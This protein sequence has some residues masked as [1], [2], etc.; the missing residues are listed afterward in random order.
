MPAKKIKV[1]IDTNL[2]I[3][4]L[5]GKKLSKLKKLISHSGI[6]LIFSHQHILELKLVTSRSKFN[7]YFNQDNVNELIDLIYSFGRIV[8]VTEE[9]EVCRDPKDNFL[10]GLAEKSKAN[11]LVSGDNDLLDMNHYKK[12]KIVSAE[13]FSK[14]IETNF[15]NS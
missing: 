15:L 2:F 7:K 3:S 4:F 8:H 1:I 14:I 9:P 10:L 6:V 13:V 12:T 5:I 11:Y